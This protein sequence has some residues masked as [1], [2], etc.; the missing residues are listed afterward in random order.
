MRLGKI[1]PLSPVLILLASTALCMGLG[2]C[3]FRLIPISYPELS[4]ESIAADQNV[5][6]LVDAGGAR[7]RIKHMIGDSFRSVYVDPQLFG[8]DYARVLFLGDSFTQ[9][10][11]LED[12][13]DRFSVVLERRINGELEEA[14]ARRR[15]NIFN[16]GIGGSYPVDWSR[17]MQR[18]A[19]VYRPNIVFAIFFLRD[20][21]SFPTSLYLNRAEID[22]IRSKY[23]DKPAYD[24]S[25]ILRFLYHKL[26]W[27]EYSEL[28]KQKMKS[29]YVGAR[30]D[31]VTWRKQQKALLRIAKACKLEGIP[32]HLAIFPMLLDLDD[33]E[34]FDVEEE[35][36]RFAQSN[37]IPVFSLTP[38][39]LGK[40]DRSLWVSATN[41]HP[42][43]E[44]HRIAAE[45]LYPHLRAA[46]DLVESLSEPLT[47][48]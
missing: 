46:I 6:G 28:F 26:A 17:Y 36:S 37:D 38:G 25:A 20:G 19:P 48:C 21:T 22:P 27:R 16:A 5:P 40:H 39:F 43:A 47:G 30:E 23:R 34:F 4:A 24:G 7:S 35:I 11:G 33:Y 32:F 1:V 8:D 44:G 10:A 42:N 3:A 18:I 45:T 31:T 14:G 9:G 2:E 13:Q 41:Q 29:A 15:L 12:L